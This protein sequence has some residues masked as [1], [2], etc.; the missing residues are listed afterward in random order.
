MCPI[1]NIMFDIDSLPEL[2]K[3]INE[4]K[5]LYEAIKEMSLKRLKFENLDKDPRLTDIK[6]PRFN[7]K[8]IFEM[9]SLSYFMCYI[10]KKPYF[11]GRK[12]C[13]KDPNRYI[14]DSN[15][16]NKL[17]CICGKDSYLTNVAG[18]NNC[19]K[20]GK[21]FI[22]YKCRY[23]CKIA[24]FFRWGITHFCEDC[25][26][27]QNMGDDITKYPKEKLSKINKETCEVGGNHAIN[28]KNLLLDAIYVEVM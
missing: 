1:C 6:S 23:C 19:L 20:H 2:Q 9:R 5:K 8:E 7:K 26:K 15:S 10:C 21:D 4:N 27:R 24:A 3:M 11:A 22:E 18:K 17:Q 13:G 16:N 14:D 25:Y 12:E 28:G